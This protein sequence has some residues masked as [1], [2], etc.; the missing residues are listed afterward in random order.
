V[1]LK[2]GEVI[3][4]ELA[5]AD[6]HPLGARPFERQQYVQ[7]F[8]ELAEDVVETAEQQRFLSAVDSLGELKS[9][10]LGAL[11]VLVDPR[12]LDKAPVIPSGIFQ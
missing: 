2:S 3:C 6:A 9:G 12:V 7:K 11:N 10:A 5:V 1:T 8:T 4:D